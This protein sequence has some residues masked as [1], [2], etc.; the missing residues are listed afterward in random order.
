MPY[1]WGGESDGLSSR[2]GAQLH[3]GYDCSGFVWRV[4][5]L[6]GN[7]A[8]LGIGGRTAAQMAGEIPKAQRLLMN[9]VGGFRSR[10]GASVCANHAGARSR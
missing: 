2:Y 1:G 3:G 8:G 4:Y 9:A 6:S 10:M 5:K 7:P